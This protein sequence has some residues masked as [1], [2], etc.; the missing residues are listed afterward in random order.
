MH[1]EG[2]HREVAPVAQHHEREEYSY[3]VRSLVHIGPAVHVQHRERAAHAHGATAWRGAVVRGV[4]GFLFGFARG[5][6][7]LCV[8]KGRVE[9]VRFLEVLL[10]C[11]ILLVA[12]VCVCFSCFYFC[13]SAALPFGHTCIVFFF[14]Q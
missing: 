5:V 12:V 7:C 11:S 4:P 8:L 14:F 10:F 2:T 1:A 13:L 6:F 3:G 9:K